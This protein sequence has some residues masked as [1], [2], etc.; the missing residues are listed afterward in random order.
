MDEDINEKHMNSEEE[1][2]S[3]KRHCNKHG[4]RI[5][6]Q[7]VAIFRELISSRKHPSA[8]MIF[9]KIKN[10]FPNISLGTVNTTLLT[11]AE[12]GVAKVVESSGEPKRFDPNT[13]PHHH[14]R[15]IK[16]GKIVDFHNDAYDAIRIPAAINKKFVVLEKKVQLE[17]LCDKCKT[18]K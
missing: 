1:L 9:K 6:P 16:C 7:R 4:L 8:S 14:F 2:I 12:I 11:F 3:F 18:K 17:G 15:C 13:Q 10:Y 5:T